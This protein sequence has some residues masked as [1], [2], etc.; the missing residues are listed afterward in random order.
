ML[1][2]LLLLWIVRNTRQTQ[3][4]L[5]ICTWNDVIPP[6]LI[7]KFEHIHGIKV[8]C[9][10]CDGMEV[11]ET[12]I[13]LGQ[14]ADYDMVLMTNR[15]F[16]QRG[17]ELYLPL[18][19]KK[20]HFWKDLDPYILR[21]LE[22]SDPKNTIAVPF[23][24]GTDGL[25]IFKERL[26][27]LFPERDLSQLNTWTM[28]FDIQELQ[29]WS[30]AGITW[31]DSNGEI[32]SAFAVYK[33]HNPF[34]FTLNDVRQWMPSLVQA[35]SFIYRW[36]SHQIIER[37]LRGEMAIAHGC[38]SVLKTLYNLGVRHKIDYVLPREG[39]TVWVDSWVLLKDN[40]I[41]YALLNFLFQPEHAALIT[42]TYYTPT[43]LLKAREFIP[44]VLL[45]DV[46]IYPPE[47]SLPHVLEEDLQ[48]K[49]L[50]YNPLENKSCIESMTHLKFGFVPLT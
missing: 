48:K 44:S 16:L 7:K 21:V 6:E 33:L 11:L 9:D 30:S 40:P 28:L 5:R 1:G 26:Q 36:E 18:D 23:L 24:W 20:L 39:V 46:G 31:L 17:K 2:I 41:A 12:R 45:Q 13:L 14:G 25:Y 35:R 32:L 10:V 34:N 42:K 22:L 27:K 15:P 49:V 8:I 29:R 43:A 3:P 50:P 37:M 4:I 38:S 19:H 47:E